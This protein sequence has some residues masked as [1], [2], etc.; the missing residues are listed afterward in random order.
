MIQVDSRVGSKEIAPLIKS[1]VNCPVKLT[2]LNS[3]DFM[4][5]GKGPK[6]PVLIGIERKCI[7]DMIS[8]MR[9]DRLAGDQLVKMN[10]DYDICYVQI[11]GIWR[12]N[13]AGLIE[14]FK[15]DRKG[16]WG[17][18]PLSLVTKGRGKRAFPY[19]EVDGH[20][21]SMESKKC[22]GVIRSYSPT[23][24]AWQVVNRYNWWR[25][26]W[27]SHRSTDPIKEQANVLFE[28]VTL[29]RY[30]FNRVPGIGWEKSKALAE[31]WPSVELMLEADP[32]DMEDVMVNGKR[33]GGNLALKIYNALRS[34]K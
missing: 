9:S 13:A 5:E 4:F 18:V 30:V 31:L 8:S 6:G 3:A 21:I 24:T 1:R 17:W 28:K 14:V 20:I 26:E 16:K 29:A 34:V 27:D 19:S 25:R 11:E 32:C 10:K 23:E 7:G 15:R 12:P 2:K 22:V 33:L